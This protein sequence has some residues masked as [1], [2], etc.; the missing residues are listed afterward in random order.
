M[1][2]DLSKLDILAPSEEGRPLFIKH[3]GTGANFKRG[4]GEPLKIV[5]RGRNSAI[6]RAELKQIGDE[7]AAI[8]ADGRMPTPE[9][10]EEWNTRYLVA[11]TVSWNFDALDGEPF[12]CNA[13][14]ARKL[15]TDPRFAWLRVPGLT[16]IAQDG[17]Y[18]GN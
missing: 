3:P 15:W 7:Q 10:R 6:A 11:M 1:Q 12:D 8:E 9:Q 13:L 18:L 16:F 17:N 2:F 14:N 5:L 4:D